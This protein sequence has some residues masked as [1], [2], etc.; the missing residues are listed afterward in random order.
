MNDCEEFR[1]P[2][3]IFLVFLNI[4]DSFETWTGLI[5]HKLCNASNKISKVNYCYRQLTDVLTNEIFVSSLSNNFNCFMFYQAW[6]SGPL[7]KNRIAWGRISGHRMWTPHLH[8]TA[9]R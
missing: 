6:S 9:V 1:N 3:V 5:E 7:R 2:I 8:V 4:G